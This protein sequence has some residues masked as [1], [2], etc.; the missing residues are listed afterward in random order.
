MADVY[1]KAA[2][3][4]QH[5]PLMFKEWDNPFYLKTV[6]YAHLVDQLAKYASA[7]GI[8]IDQS[9]CE[10]Q[11]YFNRIHKIYEQNYNGDP[12]WL[13]FHEHVHLCENYTKPE[14]A[15]LHLDYRERAGPLVKKVDPGWV[16]D[17]STKIQKGDVYLAWAELGKIPYMY[18]RDS[19]PDDIQRM[20]ELAKPW[21]HIRPKLCVALRDFDLLEN[22]DVDGFNTWWPRY[23][24]KWCQHWGI[25]N[26]DIEHMH[27]VAVIGSTNQADA[28]IDKLKNH[29][30]PTG[31]QLS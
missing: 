26:W 1:L 18:W 20:C 13:D 29:T 24:I 9:Q 16:T 28:I 22:I 23:K 2:K 25:D 14:C 21:Q 7:V 19:E 31:I 17:L 10:S 8:E 4:L 3:H 12:T 11:E 15:W 30:C 6:T 5:I 27:G